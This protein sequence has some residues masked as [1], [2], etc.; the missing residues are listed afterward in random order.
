MLIN[1]VALEMLNAKM[2][3]NGECIGTALHIKK[4]IAPHS[5]P[6]ISGQKYKLTSY[7]LGLIGIF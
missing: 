6:I 4:F 5:L 7:D 3:Q 1:V 2:P